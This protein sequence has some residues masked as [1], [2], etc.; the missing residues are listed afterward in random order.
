M[1]D[2]IGEL[3]QQPPERHHPYAGNRPPGDSS[4][5]HAQSSRRV[6]YLAEA[7][8]AKLVSVPPCSELGPQG[9]TDPNELGAV[10]QPREPDLPS[11]YTAASAMIVGIGLFDDLPTLLERRQ[12]PPLT[13]ATYDP[14]AALRRIERDAGSYREVRDHFI[15]AQIALAEQAG[16]VHRLLFRSTYRPRL[17]SVTTPPAQGSPEPTKSSA[18]AASLQS[19]GRI[20]G[21]LRCA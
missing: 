7:S 1:D 8:A 16:R 21:V 11:G 9:L 12:V 10:R 14:Q 2:A 6:R 4:T 3:C 18:S 5:D 13:A 19:G 17:Q 20:G 15:A